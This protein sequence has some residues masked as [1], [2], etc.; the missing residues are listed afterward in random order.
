MAVKVSCVS[1]VS[2]GASYCK[3]VEASHGPLA[4]AEA[5]CGVVRLN[6]LCS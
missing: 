6:I 3:A 4:C 2:G 5:S 1:V